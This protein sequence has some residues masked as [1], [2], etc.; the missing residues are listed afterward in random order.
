MQ[1]VSAL[2]ILTLGY[3]TEAL[4]TPALPVLSYD[5]EAKLDVLVRD[6]RETM[7]YFGGIG[8]AAPQVGVGLRVIVVGIEGGPHVALANPV[9]E[10]RSE[11]TVVDT[12]GC[13]SLPG[14][15]RQ[16][17]RPRRVRVQ[18]VDLDTLRVVTIEA[19]DLYARVLQH[20]IDHLDGIL[21]IDRPEVR[22]WRTL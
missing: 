15:V 8:L 5:P 4:R 18:A 10:W 9:I 6:M 22:P 20:E 13:L 16:V 2:S 7:E 11:K 19:K 14:V 1:G 12:E 3:S 17:R 21:I